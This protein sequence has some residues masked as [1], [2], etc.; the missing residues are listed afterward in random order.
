MTDIGLTHFGWAAAHGL[1]SAW[2]AALGYTANTNL[3]QIAESLFPGS[4]VAGAAL[5]PAAPLTWPDRIIFKN[6]PCNIYLQ[7]VVAVLTEHGDEPFAHVHIEMPPVRHLDNPAASG[8][9]QMRNSAQAVAA[10]AGCLP[11]RYES[12]T[13]ASL[14]ANSTTIG[15]LMAG[16][17][18][19][20]QLSSAPTSLLEAEIRIT[21]TAA[22]RQ[23]TTHVRRLTQTDP[24]STAVAR[25][26]VMGASY[27]DTIEALSSLPYPEAGLLLRQALISAPIHD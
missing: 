10:I 21:V 5:A 9:R 25:R 24:W 17:V 1:E 6:Y 20:T 8:P 14:T 2:L 22:D 13:S 11:G 18:T 3:T 26:V 7:P 16:A 12:F 19:V 4:D 27:A 15:R 23:V